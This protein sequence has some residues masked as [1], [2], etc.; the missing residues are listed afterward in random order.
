MTNDPT[1]HLTRWGNSGPTVVMIHGSVQG[2]LI[3]GDR[4]F[5]AQEKL[6][7]RGWQIIVP[8]RPGHGRSPSP[9]RPDDGVLDGHWVAKLLG[10]GAHLV[11]HSFG[12]LVAL[13]AAA[14]RPQAVRSLTLIEPAI[15]QLAATDPVVAAYF[16]RQIG[17][18]TSGKS[19][20]EILADFSKVAGIPSSLR[21]K[22]VDANEATRVGESLLKVHFPPDDEMQELVAKVAKAKLPVLIVTGGWNPA[23]DKSAS[24]IAPQMGGRHQIVRSPDHFP[25][26]AS[27]EFNDVLDRFMRDADAAPGRDSRH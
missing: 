13:C 10:D 7:A 9:G 26:L 24:I 23:F 3:T 4:H 20:A 5:S 8:D 1:I 14:E 11:G 12:G 18:F 6:V 22:H 16:K 15:H 25:Q 19:P 17:I 2:S 27:E 21:T